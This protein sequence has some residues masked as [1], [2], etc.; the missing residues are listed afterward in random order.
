MTKEEII[1]EAWGELFE[2]YEDRISLEDGYLHYKSSKVLKEVQSV[3]QNVQ[4]MPGGGVSIFRPKSL[5]GI[6]HNNGWIKIQSE[7][8]LPNEKGDYWVI[9][10]GKIVIQYWHSSNFPYADTQKQNSDWMKIVTHYQPIEKPKPPI[11]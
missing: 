11:Y 7:E 8:D 6:E 10:D 5:Q 4:F 3:F 1:K 2:K 9:W